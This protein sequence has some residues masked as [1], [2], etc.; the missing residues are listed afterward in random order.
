VPD[1]K[2]SARAVLS[3]GIDVARWYSERTRKTPRALGREYA[4]L[5]LRMLGSSTVD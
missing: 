1:E 4:T 5:V 2:T 3:L